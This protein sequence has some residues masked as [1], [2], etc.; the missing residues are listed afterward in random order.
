MEDNTLDSIKDKV[1]VVDD[2]PIIC[3][4]P[5]YIVLNTCKI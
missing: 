3:N 4:S 2:N 5:R 1:L